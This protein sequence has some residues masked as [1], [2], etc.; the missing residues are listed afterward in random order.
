MS[1]YDWP[2]AYEYTLAWITGKSGHCGV[3]DCCGWISHDQY[4][5]IDELAANLAGLEQYPR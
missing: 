4:K 3:E 2:D 1:Y 5:Q